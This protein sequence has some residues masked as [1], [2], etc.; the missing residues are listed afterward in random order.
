M[1]ISQHDDL[2]QPSLGRRAPSKQ[3][4]PRRR[5]FEGVAKPRAH[6]FVQL[7]VFDEVLFGGYL[8]EPEVEDGLGLHEICGITQHHYFKYP[9]ACIFFQ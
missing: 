2:R 9:V 1:Q 3:L 6:D 4:A 7:G 8:F 5:R